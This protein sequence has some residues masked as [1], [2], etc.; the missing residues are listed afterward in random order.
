MRAEHQQP[1]SGRADR[2][3]PAR[4]PAATSLATLASGWYAV[5]DQIDD[6]LDDRVEHLGTI[7]V[8]MQS[9]SI[10]HSMRRYSQDGGKHQHRRRDRQVDRIFRWP[11]PHARSPARR[12]RSWA[13]R[14]PRGTGADGTSASRVAQIR[15]GAFVALVLGRGRLP[16]ADPP[17]P[18]ASCPSPPAS[19]D[20]GR[21]GAAGHERAGSR[22]PSPRYA[23]SLP[24]ARAF[25][26]SRSR[27]RPAVPAYRRARSASVSPDPSI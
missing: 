11:A 20:H 3:S 6:R 27:C 2:R 16:Q 25:W 19:G 9:S 10:A 17:P 5:G 26:G 23:H 8:T 7:T 24:P 15:D 4:R 1:D 14:R 21:A 12:S 13:A 18:R 22:T